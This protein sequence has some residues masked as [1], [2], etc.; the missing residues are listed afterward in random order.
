MCAFGLFICRPLVVVGAC[1][2][3]CTVC[4]LTPFCHTA[5][6]RWVMLF[7]HDDDDDDAGT[8]T[9]W[10]CTRIHCQAWI[11]TSM[12]SKTRSVCVH[13]LCVCALCVFVCVRGWSLRY[14]GLV[15]LFEGSAALHFLAGRHSERASV[16]AFTASFFATRHACFSLAFSSLQQTTGGGP[17]RHPRW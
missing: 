2:G 1:H 15:W 5:A 7:V 14:P 9:T 17:G 16:R 10:T 4:Q 12:P 11:S 3:T 13:A 6:V 8:E